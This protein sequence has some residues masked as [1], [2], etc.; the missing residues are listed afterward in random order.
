MVRAVWWL[1]LSALRRFALPERNSF[2]SCLFY[3]TVVAWLRQKKNT[4]L[5]TRLATQLHLSC[6]K[7]RLYRAIQTSQTAPHPQTRPP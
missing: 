3:T 2:D 6:P 1:H 7:K 5:G 4:F